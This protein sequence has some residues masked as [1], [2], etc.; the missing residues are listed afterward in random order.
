VEHEGTASTELGE[1]YLCDAVVYGGDVVIE[2]ERWC[3]VPFDSAGAASRFASSLREAGMDPAGTACFGAGSPEVGGSGIL[4][5]CL[6][7]AD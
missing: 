7:D 1:K 6:L 2:R 5:P 3:D 4:I